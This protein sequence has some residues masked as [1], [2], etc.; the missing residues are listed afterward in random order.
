MGCVCVCVCV[1]FLTDAVHLPRPP[2][3]GQTS[4]I[5]IPQ[6]IE[7]HLRRAEAS[8]DPPGQ[9]LVNSTHARRPTGMRKGWGRSGGILRNFPLHSSP[10]TIASGHLSLPSSVLRSRGAE[11]ALNRN[12]PWQQNR[13]SRPLRWVM[14]TQPTY[15]PPALHSP[16]CAH[17]ALMLG[18]REREGLS[19]GGG[20]GRAIV[21]KAIVS[22]RPPF[23]VI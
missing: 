12:D 5:H 17:L 22:Q 20:Q 14:S 7:G 19:G 15:P 9:T 3:A 23:R 11:T 13:L 8:L 1:P 21:T 18:E 4:L 10:D 6:I 16:Y 2:W